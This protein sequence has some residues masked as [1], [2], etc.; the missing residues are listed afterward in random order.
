MA[1]LDRQLEYWDTEG[2]RKAFAHPVNLQRVGQWLS[3]GSR[4]LD[5]GCGYGRCLG[6]L[7]SAGY[8]DL[9]GFDFSPA[10]I[11]AARARFPE[12]AFQ[13]LQSSTIP[14]PDGRDCVRRF[15]TKDR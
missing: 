15:V 14:L 4:I 7:F 10:M 6:E 3:P 9:I 2:T 5:F 13:E 8:R 12:I 11:V 1:K